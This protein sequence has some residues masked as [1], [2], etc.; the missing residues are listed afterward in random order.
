MNIV[1]EYNQILKAAEYVKSVSDI[2]PDTAIVLG[3]GM[4]SIISNASIVHK[5][6]YE[7]IPFFP[8]TTIEGHIGNLLIARMGSK[9][10]FVMQGRFHFYEG[11]SAKEITFP[12]RVLSALNVRNLVLTNAAGGLSEQMEAGDLLSICD[13]LSFHCESPLRGLNMDQFGPRFPDQTE[14]YNKKFIELLQEIAQMKSIRM[15]VG[16]YAYMRGPQYETPAE[17][18]VLRN[19]GTSAVGM[20]TVP[21]AIVAS[22]CGMRVAA[23]SCISNLASGMTSGGLS[24]LEVIRAANAAAE[25]MAILLEAFIDNIPGTA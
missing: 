25:K 10:V 5:I 2:C 19:M 7:A 18:A 9:N 22:H 13:H 4:S 8:K 20:S 21:E 24:H 1:E 15:H 17:I 12:I 23:I 14:V 11:Y 6:P 3:S 16:V